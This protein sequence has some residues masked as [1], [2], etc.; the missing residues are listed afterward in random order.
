[1]RKTYLGNNVVEG[2]SRALSE[3][4]QVAVQVAEHVA[5]EFED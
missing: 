3:K 1:M 2:T 4:V 5:T